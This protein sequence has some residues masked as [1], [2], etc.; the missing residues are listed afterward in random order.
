[1]VFAYPASYGNLTKI[2]DAN[3]FDVTGTFTKSTVNVSCA[4]GT[5]VPYN[6]YVNSAS[7][8]SGFNMDF[9]F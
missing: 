6:V 5:S 9:R 2:Y 8:V 3:N 7:T 4:D 1:M